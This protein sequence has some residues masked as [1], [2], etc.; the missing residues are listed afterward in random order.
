[1]ERIVFPKPEICNHLDEQTQT[2]FL[3]NA[4][5]DNKG[6]RVDYFF[7]QFDDLYGIMENKQRLKTSDWRVYITNRAGI[8]SNLKFSLALIINLILVLYF[9][10]EESELLVYYSGSRLI[11][12]RINGI[13]G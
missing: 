12:R 6:S 5:S 13:F 2:S 9:P 4:K 8:W 7:K 3:K 1:M 10:F 11:G